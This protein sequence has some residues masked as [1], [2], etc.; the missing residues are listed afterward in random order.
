M[1]FLEGWAISTALSYAGG[2]VATWVIGWILKSI[3]N[4]TIRKKFGGLMYGLG[5]LVTAGLSK[6]KLTKGFWNKIIEPWLIDFIDNIV[7][8]G[9]NEFIRGMRSDDKD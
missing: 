3:P 4:D 9:I 1:G 7:G 5:V 6:W 8:H 2:F